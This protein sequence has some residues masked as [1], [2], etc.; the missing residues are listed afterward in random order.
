VDK[1]EQEFLYGTSLPAGLGSNDIGLDRGLIGEDRIVKFTKVGRKLLLVQPNYT[2]RAVTTNAAEQKAVEQSFSQS[3]LWGFTIEAESDNKYLV[4][5]TDF[6]LRDAMKAAQRIRSMRK[7]N[8]A[9]DKSRSAFYLAGT[10]NF[11]SIPKL[12]PASP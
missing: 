12:K 1:P 6:F 10:K 2:Y 4:D 7:G 11:R 8:Y 9:Y 5:A 3:T